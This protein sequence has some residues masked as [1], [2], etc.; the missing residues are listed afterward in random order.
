MDFIY[1]ND[2]INATMTI[3]DIGLPTGFDVDENDL[4][5]LSTGK[6]RYVQQYENNEVLSERGSLI[7]YVNKVSNKEREKIAFP[8]HKTLNVGLLQ[9][10]TVTIYEYYSPV[11]E[12]L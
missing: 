5:A 12:L 3:L 4:K 6:D 7:L 2:T 8:M 10:A 11:P 9:P 1:K